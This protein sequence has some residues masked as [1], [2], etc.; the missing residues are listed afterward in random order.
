MKARDNPFATSRVLRIRYQLRGTTWDALMERWAALRHR[1]AIVGPHGGGKTTL[2]EDWEPRLAAAGWRV[3]W[4]RLSEDNR[5]LPPGHLRRWTRTLGPRDCILF[6][7]AEQMSRWGW[8]WFR[9][10]SLR[11]G[12]ILV[13]SH[14]PGLLPTLYECRT[15]AALLAGIACRLAGPGVLAAGASEA[16][17]AR[18]SGNVRN[19]L[20]DLYDQATTGAVPAIGKTPADV[21]GER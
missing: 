20:R 16:L 3:H 14:M 5:R 13:T 7:G 21:F 18:H 4:L 1:A 6:D 10:R 9:R 8:A 19:A 11:A 15:D 12:G 2:L 17:Y